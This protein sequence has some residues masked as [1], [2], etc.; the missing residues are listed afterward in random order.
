MNPTAAMIQDYLRGQGLDNEVVEFAQSTKTAQEAAEVLGCRVAQIAKAIIF[1]GAGSGRGILAVTSGKNR[2]CEQKVAALVGE[3]LGKANATF[4][5]E[6]TGYVIG[7]VPPMAHAQAMTVLIDEDLL[8]EEIIWAAAG[9]PNSMFPLTPD[10][11]LR[12]TGGRV[13]DVKQDQ[14]AGA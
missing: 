8:A 4:V 1:R 14:P 9:T 11:L 10:E 5:R 2:V 7:G 13:A 6:V 12:L 3:A